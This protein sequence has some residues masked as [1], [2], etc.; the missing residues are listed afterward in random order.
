[1]TVKVGCGFSERLQN[2]DDSTAH[3]FKTALKTQRTT[4]LL[5]FKHSLMDIK[6]ATRAA[7][8]KG[9]ADPMHQASG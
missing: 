1:M 3:A 2:G 6:E 8:I 9:H 4:C 7:L 5:R